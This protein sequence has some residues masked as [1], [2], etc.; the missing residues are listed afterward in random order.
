MEYIEAFN[1]L[2]TTMADMRQ[3]ILSLEAKVN[4]LDGDTPS[5]EA[6][7]KRIENLENYDWQVSW[8]WEVNS[9]IEAAIENIDWEDNVRDAL[10]NISFSITVD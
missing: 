2:I 4:H 9:L 10:G 1:V 8:E 3:R 5:V 6:L 7:V